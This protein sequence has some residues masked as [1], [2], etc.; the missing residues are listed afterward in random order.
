[1]LAK[2]SHEALAECHDLTVRLALRIKVG[3]ALAAAH[4]KAC[5]AVLEDLLKSEELDDAEVYSRVESQTALVRTDSRVELYSVACVYLNLSVVIYP[6]NSEL[7]LSLRVYK[8]LKKS[9]LSVLLLI[10]L[11]YNSDSL[12]NLLDCLVELRLCRVL[13]NYLCNDFINIRHLSY[14]LKNNIKKDNGHTYSGTH[15]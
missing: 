15:C 1:M 12:K 9:S 5:K 6:R 8:S 11:D 7:D 3:T 14:L 13:F 4:R 10:S 2:L